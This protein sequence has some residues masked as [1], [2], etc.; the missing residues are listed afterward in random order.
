MQQCP[1]PQQCRPFLLAHEEVLN[2]CR[3]GKKA[4]EMEKQGLPV[5]HLYHI[6]YIPKYTLAVFPSSPPCQ[7]LD[8]A[9]FLCAGFFPSF[10][11]RTLIMFYSS[12]VKLSWQFSPNFFLLYKHLSSFFFSFKHPQDPRWTH[13]ALICELRGGWLIAGTCL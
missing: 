12:D 2:T 1:H 7:L 3:R 4:K 11:Y 9:L 8:L 6:C 13:S 10:N 5:V